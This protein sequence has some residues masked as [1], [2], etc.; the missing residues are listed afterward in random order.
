MARKL[1]D[2]IRKRDIL[3]S[4]RTTPA[5]IS[6]YG[7][8]FLKE[9]LYWDAVEF[10]GGAGDEE[11]LKQVRE[12]GIEIADAYLL[13]RV[14]RQMPKLVKPEDWLYGEDLRHTIDFRGIY[15]TVLEQWMGMDPT[16][17]VGGQFEQLSPYA[18]MPA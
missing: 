8:L 15:G 12:A 6:E 11:G 5:E 18:A 13:R 14:A 7:H 3:F 9:E 4:E 16:A 1:P 10:F 2:P 17:I